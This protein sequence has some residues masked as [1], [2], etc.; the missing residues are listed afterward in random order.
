MRLQD[1]VRKAVEPEATP[2]A[3]PQPKDLISP[4]G[5][6]LALFCFFLPWGR[7]TCAGFNRA[8]TG[9]QIGGS[10]WLVFAL[11]LAI[12]ASV[13]AGFLLRQ[14]RR[15]R[16]TVLVC[17]LAA[18]AIILV[19]QINF[20]RGHETGF[21]RVH[22]EDVGVRLRFGG[23]GTVLGL[24]IALAGSIAWRAARSR[25]AETPRRMPPP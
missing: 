21:G 13:A 5:A 9:A 25:R 3:N 1:I 7:F 12:P 15:A 10:F 24:L 6:V 8:L 11:A 18:L 23:A 4:A 2:V 20:V 14:Q 22:A 19:R 16:L 17:S